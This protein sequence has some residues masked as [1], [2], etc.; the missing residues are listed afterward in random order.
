MSYAYSIKPNFLTQPEWVG[1]AT[2]NVMGLQNIPAF[3]RF[4]TNILFSNSCENFDTTIGEKEFSDE[5]IA[6]SPN[7]FTNKFKIKVETNII[8]LKIYNALGKLMLKIKGSDR[9]TI[10][11]SGKWRNGIYFIDIL[12]ADGKRVVKRPAKT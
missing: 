1:I 9:E 2:P 4:T 3:D 10:I 11:D 5:Q 12:L 6:I 8:Y 7:P